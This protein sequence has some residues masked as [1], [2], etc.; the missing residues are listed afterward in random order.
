MGFQT[1]RLQVTMFVIDVYLNV[2]DCS[3]FFVVQKEKILLED[4]KRRN[5]FDSSSIDYHISRKENFE[6]T[7]SFSGDDE[8]KSI[9]E[10]IELN[11]V[12][13]TNFVMSNA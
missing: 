5:F 6:K 9:E 12:C 10:M 7:K 13:C 1:K 8:E 4:T 11:L 2:N 3:H